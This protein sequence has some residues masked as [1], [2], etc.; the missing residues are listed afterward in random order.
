MAQ[1][2]SGQVVAVYDGTAIRLLDALTGQLTA[3]IGALATGP[4]VIGATAHVLVGATGPL[5]SQYP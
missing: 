4:V 5:G 3:R 2:D 1:Q